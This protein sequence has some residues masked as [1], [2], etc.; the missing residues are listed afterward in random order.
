A[1]LTRFFEPG[2][3]DIGDLRIETSVRQFHAA[4]L[5]Y[6]RIS[7]RLLSRARYDLFAVYLKGVDGLSHF[8][9]KYSALFP[10]HVLDK[11]REARYGGSLAEYYRYADDQ[12][13]GL[14]TFADADTD[15]VVCSDHGF[16]WQPEGR[17]AHEHAPAGV[18]IL[19]G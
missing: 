10:A 8:T 2:D 12:L 3:G 4:D 19:A 15:V 5:T 9:G 11:Q 13:A 18:F 14:L 1:Q 7:Q 6:T 16:E 17:F